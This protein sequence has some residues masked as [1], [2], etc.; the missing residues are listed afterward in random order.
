M[1]E[2]THPL[3]FC[4]EVVGESIVRLNLE[5]YAFDDFHPCLL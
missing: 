2:V 4:L 3:P 1:D 5:H